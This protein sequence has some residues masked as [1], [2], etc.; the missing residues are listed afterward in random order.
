LLAARG[1]AMLYFPR[2]EEYAMPAR[3]GT[4]AREG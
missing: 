1:A 2:T 3:N 4:D